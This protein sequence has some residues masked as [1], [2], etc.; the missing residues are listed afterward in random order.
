MM[1]DAAN[2]RNSAF[3]AINRF[4]EARHHYASLADLHL[5]AR[6]KVADEYLS[7]LMLAYVSEANCYLL[8]EEPDTASRILIEGREALRVRTRRY[9]EILLTSNPAAYLHPS[10]QTEISLD[11]LTSIFQWLEPSANPS[12]VFETQRQNLFDLAQQPGKW[13][14]T[15]PPAIWDPR[16]DTQ[17]APAPQKEQPTSRWGRVTSLV[18]TEKLSDLSSTITSKFGSIRALEAKVFARLPAA[19]AAMEAMIEDADRLNGY[20]LEVQAMRRLGL[21]FADWR[22]LGDIK[23][24]EVACAEVIYLVPAEPVQIGW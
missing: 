17:D 24:I 9:V 3:Q 16:V 10:L 20:Y 7:T 12:T 14:E 8:L 11:R 18:P 22:A 21:S 19:M 4:A 15:L 5:A 13:I 1:R 6:S 2:R 23:G